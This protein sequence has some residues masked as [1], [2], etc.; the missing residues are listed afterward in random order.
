MITS[1]H[2]KRKL[3]VGSLA[4]SGQM[5]AYSYN[6]KFLER[7]Q[8]SLQMQYEAAALDCWSIGPLQT[9]SK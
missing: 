3:G 4:P 9:S 2:K 1:E 6:N 7:S 5:S 8:F